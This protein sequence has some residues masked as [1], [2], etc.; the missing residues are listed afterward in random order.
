M[1]EHGDTYSDYCWLSPEVQ[2]Q[3]GL[4]SPPLQYCL[5]NINN[6]TIALCLTMH[7]SQYCVNQYNWSDH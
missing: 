6:N 3:K 4:P 2:R 5:L 7:L 1:R